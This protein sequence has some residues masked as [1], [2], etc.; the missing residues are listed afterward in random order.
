[1]RY[2]TRII[3][4]PRVK[5]SGPPGSVG[6]AYR[7][8]VLG[9][10]RSF[11]F[12]DRLGVATPGHLAA[13]AAH[14]GF[15]PVFA[16][17]SVR[18]LTRTGRTPQDVIGTA[19]SAISGARFRHPWGADADRL[20]HSPDVEAAAAAGYTYFTID[21]VEFVRADADRMPADQLATVIESMVADGEFSEDWSGP[22]LERAI[23]LPGSQRLR[24][25]LEP[26]QRAVVK[27]GRAINHCARMS[28]TVARASQGRPF[29]IGV[30]FD[31]TYTPTTT[32][33]HLFIGLELE[34]RGVRL[35]SLA[36]HLPGDWERGIDYRGDLAAFEAQL[37][38]H[39]AVA[40][41]CGP[42]KLSFHHGSDKPSVY[43]IIG[44]CCGDALHVKTSG[45]SY[46][47]AL[48]VV[49]RTDAAL[50]GQ[51]VHYSRGRFEGDRAG[52]SVATTAGEVEQLP[53]N[54]AGDEEQ[55]FLN[56]RA[57]RQLLHVTYGSVL[58]MGRDDQGRP[59][60]D[61]IL[62][63]L[64]RHADIYHELL[65]AHLGDHMRLLNAG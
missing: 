8:Q 51:I 22:Y 12:G 65:A 39:V 6:G 13:L 11:G 41:F 17:Q 19:I 64:D 34:A 30:T 49:L 9:V 44:R 24:I 26:L 15:A 54:T 33:E 61:A 27:F 36:L 7:P 35:T 3:V 47:E 38:E 53:E 14:P 55:I 28:E 29:E 1:M 52:I 57:G 10:R 48:R 42:Y 62:E 23:D 31:E 37:K 40:E 32:L 46:L 25:G 56:E 5:R 18:E 21:P 43:Q 50:F 4:P 20:R 45:T 16:Q 63:L 2:T 59:F 60:K 58:T